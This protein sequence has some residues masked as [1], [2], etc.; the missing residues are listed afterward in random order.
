MVVNKDYDTFE[1]YGYKITDATTQKYEK[2]FT[3][4]KEESVQIMGSHEIYWFP[5]KSMLLTKL[6]DG[7]S[8]K[9]YRLAKNF[10]SVYTTQGSA[11]TQDLI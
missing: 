7:S 11:A 8:F 9:L 3:S 4:T 2:F 10:Q 1:I 5:Y 6:S